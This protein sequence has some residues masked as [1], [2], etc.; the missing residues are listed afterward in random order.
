MDISVVR[1]KST[2]NSWSS[3][4]DQ[5]D[6]AGRDENVLLETAGARRGSA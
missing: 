1:G 6:V 4:K 2:G 5:P 3:K